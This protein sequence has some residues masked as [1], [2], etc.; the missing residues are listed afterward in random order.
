MDFEKSLQRLEEILKK[1]E[2][3]NL[4]LEEAINL[5]QEG[6]ALS[7]KCKQELETAKQ[8]IS[9]FDISGEKNDKSE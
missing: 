9:E 5:Y 7:V 8:K 2:E 6:T 1:L 4:S 3:G